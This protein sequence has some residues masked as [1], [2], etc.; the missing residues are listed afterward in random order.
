MPGS[1]FTFSAYLGAISKPAP[2][3]WLGA[4]IALTAIYLPSFLLLIGILPF[5]NRL[6]AIEPFQAALR[7]INAA[8]VGIL[9][10]AL[11]Q[12]IW[13]S[14]IHAPIDFALALLAAG[15]LMIWK[16]PPWLVVLLSAL[17][18]F[19]VSLL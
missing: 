10:A 19:G 6:R 7:G 3:G 11:Y 13:T 16:W 12:P 17:L 18:G 14:A 8:V 5:W 4:A 9:L 2:D 1:L 15:L